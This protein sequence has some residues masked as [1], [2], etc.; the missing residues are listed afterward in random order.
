[1]TDVLNKLVKLL[2]PKVGGRSIRWRKPG[3]R[4]GNGLWWPGFRSSARIGSTVTAERAAHSLHGYSLNRD[5]EQPVHYAVERLRDGRSFS[6]RRVTAR[7]GATIIFTMT[8]SFQVGQSG[9]EH[10][11]DAPYAPP[12]T[13]LPS[14]A[15]RARLLARQLPEKLR[16][17]A[18]ASQAIETRPVDPI[19]PFN[20][21]RCDAKQRI[22][23]KANGGLPS[24]RSLHQ[25]L[26]AYASDFSFLTTAL[27]PHGVSWL[28]PG[29]RMASLDHSLWFHRPITMDTWLLNAIEAPVSCGARAL[30]R[31][32]LFDQSGQLVASA[33][34]EGMVR[35]KDKNQTH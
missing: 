22:W 27:R 25:V 11:I 15:E 10:S 29:I 32:H 5:V 23:M 21:M 35:M 1:M 16:D 20:P 34:Q 28:T 19:D 33:A 12:A 26:L 9:F 3:L 8:A 17:R 18:L 4:L 30:V 13:E 31:G 7:Q 2:S 14:S 6:A 24:H